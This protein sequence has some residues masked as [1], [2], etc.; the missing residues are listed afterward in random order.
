MYQFLP[1]HSSWLHFCVNLSQTASISP[2][3][4]HCSPHRHYHLV[5]TCCV[6]GK[7]SIRA[8]HGFGTVDSCSL[9]SPTTSTKR[10]LS[11]TPKEFINWN[12]Q[13]TKEATEIGRQSALTQTSPP[14]VF[15]DAALLVH[16]GHTL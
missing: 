7:S 6:R 2:N 3:L 15:K 8:Q 13:E 1:T 11:F 9:S 14:L 10:Q 4:G 16:S 5:F 12:G